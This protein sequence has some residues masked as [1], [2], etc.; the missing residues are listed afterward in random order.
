M[1]ICYLFLNGLEFVQQLIC[2]ITSFLCDVKLSSAILLINFHPRLPGCCIWLSLCIPRVV[3]LKLFESDDQDVVSL[4]GLL[5]SQLVNHLYLVLQHTHPQRFSNRIGVR[6]NIVQ[7][8]IK[9]TILIEK[10]S[11]CS[12]E[13]PNELS[14]VFFSRLPWSSHSF[15]S[16]AYESVVILLLDALHMIIWSACCEWTHHCR[17]GDS[18]FVLMQE[19]INSETVKARILKL[20]P[21]CDLILTVL[22]HPLLLFHLPCDLQHV[23]YVN[24][25]FCVPFLSSVV[26][27][28]TV[29]VPLI[30]NFEP[31]AEVLKG[32]DRFLEVWGIRR[33]TSLEQLERKIGVF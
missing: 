12:N 4:V 5:P 20:F 30:R 27:R 25:T 15:W 28:S 22:L 21:L 3:L 23:A 33:G 6:S 32:S 8:C 18:L 14:C 2:R 19:V 17:N 11:V 10:L 29:G 9:R 16:C 24:S 26:L 7:F 1:K 13:L 31:V